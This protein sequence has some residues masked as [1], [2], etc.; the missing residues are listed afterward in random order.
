MTVREFINVT[1]FGRYSVVCGEVSE[2]NMPTPVNPENPLEMDAFGGYIV[3]AVQTGL[4]DIG[5]MEI[6]G[7]DG[8]PVME[9]EIHVRGSFAKDS[10]VKAV[11]V[12]G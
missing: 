9:A 5:G 6:R 8:K 4:F 10:R 12:H 1:D 11:K 3:A 7:E 2:D